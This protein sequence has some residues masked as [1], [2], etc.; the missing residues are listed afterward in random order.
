MKTRVSITRPH[1]RRLLTHEGP[2]GT[3][4]GGTGGSEENPKDS[5][6]ASSALASRAELVTA[7]DSALSAACGMFAAAVRGRFMD[8]AALDEAYETLITSVE[9]FRETVPKA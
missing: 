4:T 3:L 7:L 2:E 9:V 5:P 8:R 1:P 6:L